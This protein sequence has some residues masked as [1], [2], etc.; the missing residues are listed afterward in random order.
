MSDSQ[1]ED[2]LLQ[3]TLAEY[4]P[5]GAG[6]PPPWQLWSQF[7][8]AFLGGPLAATAVA[9]LN[10]KRLGL[11]A[12]RRR[13]ILAI[14]LAGSVA[15]AAAAGYYS[16][17]AGRES[18]RAIRI[19]VRA[20]ALL[21]FGCFYAMQ[22]SADR[23]YQVNSRPVPA[24]ASLWGP[25]AAIVIGSSLLTWVLAIAAVRLWSGTP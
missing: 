6:G 21:L 23:L 15:A 12:K 9:W 20:A 1:S 3:P 18:L 22:K 17:G 13:L 5:P 2:E 8:V 14:G 10:S 25:G 7:Y 24:F 4:R 16:I 19:G 11:D